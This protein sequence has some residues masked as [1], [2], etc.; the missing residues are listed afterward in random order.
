MH[1]SQGRGDRYE[2]RRS[3]LMLVLTRKANEQIQ[4]GDNVVITI[5]QV[6]GQSVR[7]GIEAPREV[8]VLRSELPRADEV[9]FENPMAEPPGRADHAKS[10]QNRGVM[11]RGL[12][13]ASPL[14]ASAAPLATRVEHFRLSPS[15]RFQTPG[16]VNRV[17]RLHSAI[18][19]RPILPTA[20]STVAAL[21]C[22]GWGL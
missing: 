9:P 19:P 1:A 12:L 6:K 11:P 21:D 14:L 20:N 13:K 4:I 8:R 17:A 10:R 7:I 2:T 22:E 18:E 5:L 16:L 3:F 15:D